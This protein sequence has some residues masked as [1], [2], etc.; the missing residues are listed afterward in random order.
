[1]FGEAEMTSIGEI[2]RLSPVIPVLTI[3][4]VAQARQIGEALMAGGLRVLEVTLR[5]PAA[6]DV[7]REMRRIDGAVV[8]A[9]TV[10]SERQLDD[11]LAAGAEFAISPGL[12]ERVVS[13]AAAC[14][15]PYLP[16]VLTAT[17]IMRGL[18][19]GL[20]HFKFFPAAA[21][22]GTAALKALSAPFTDAR[23][24]PTGGITE[25][26]ASE[27]LKLRQVL[28]VGGSWLVPQGTRN[29]ASIEA[30]ARRAASLHPQIEE[31]S[32]S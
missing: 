30:A 3:D 24:C 13:A 29:P 12:N 23:F 4:D 6:L 31:A 28:C 2:L 17:E 14:G 32:A 5:T 20:S 8:G 15:I 9:G 16:G 22:G 21:A 18:D 26:T 19:L 1:M 7:I 10:L 27:W 25:E 11:C